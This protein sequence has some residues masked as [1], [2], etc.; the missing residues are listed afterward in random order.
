MSRLTI[1]ELN[2]ALA[3][4]G[5]SQK[6]F[7]RRERRAQ[8]RSVLFDVP[9]RS[10]IGW[11]CV[12]ETAAGFLRRLTTELIPEEAGQ[13]MKRLCSRPYYL[14]LS[15]LMS[16]FFGA[17]QQRILDA[18]LSAGEA[19]AEDKVDEALAVVDFWRRTCSAYRNDGL[20]LPAQGGDTQSILPPERVREV[21]AMLQ[22]T[23]IARRKQLR[24][25]AATLELYCFIL[26][27][28][29]RDGI[30]AHG[31]YPLEGDILVVQEFTDLQNDFLP[32][33]HTA[34][35]N[36]YPH[37]ALALRLRGVKATFDLYGGV[38]FEPPDITPHI[39]AETLLTSDREGTIRPVP[40]QEVDSIQHC[41]AEGQGELYLKAA[42]WAPRF[43][44]EYGVHLFANHLRSF[45]HLLPAGRHCDAEIHAAFE[46]AAALEI[47]RLLACPEPLSMW[48][49]MAT[50]EGDFF[51]PVAAARRTHHP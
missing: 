10:S 9:R 5:E 27:G 40:L 20:W 3:L 22:D 19:W 13:R 12:Y 33:A 28:E 8:L 41:A 42:E 16:S 24:R 48:K 17:R 43:K 30:F 26:H 44:A 29:Q 47:D 6:A 21:A 50:T 37:L 18:G 31:P 36:P 45:F 11:H 35:R 7:M 32:W 25:L 46:E 39:V 15:I 23:G 38:L 2:R 49:F 51:W 34:V 4:F 1:P 14:T